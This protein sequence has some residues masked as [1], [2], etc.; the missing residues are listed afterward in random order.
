MT[1]T[2]LLIEAIKKSGLKMTFVADRLGISRQSLNRK[3]KNQCQFKA[4]EIKEFGDIL[5]LSGKEK[6]RIFFA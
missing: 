2:E 3:I 5:N 4:S 6:E 1:N